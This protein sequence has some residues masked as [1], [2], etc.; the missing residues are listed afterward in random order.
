MH[1]DISYPLIPYTGKMYY[2]QK[3]ELILSEVPLPTLVSEPKLNQSHLIIPKRTLII[4]QTETDKEAVKE[5][6]RQKIVL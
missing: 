3:F 2:N 4:E 1:K 5:F 6:I